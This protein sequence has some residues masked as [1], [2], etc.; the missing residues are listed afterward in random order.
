[1]WQPCFKGW[2]LYMKIFV[3][4]HSILNRHLL[5]MWL[6]SKAIP[7][8]MVILMT[9]RRQLQNSWGVNPMRFRPTILELVTPLWIDLTVLRQLVSNHML[10]TSKWAVFFVELF[11]HEAIG[12]W[13]R[14]MQMW[15]EKTFF[16]SFLKRWLVSQE[17][18]ERKKSF[19][20]GF[21][22]KCFF[23]QTLRNKKCLPRRKKF[24]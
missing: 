3:F 4:A 21:D 11:W 20:S 14:L 22:E 2:V 18:K 9:N 1:M 10:A 7:V 24:G 13:F 16:F 6:L 15:R 5:R 8:V 17:M 23:L 19:F 12:W